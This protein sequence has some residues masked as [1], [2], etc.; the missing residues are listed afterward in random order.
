MRRKFTKYPQGYVKASYWGGRNE[1]P[2]NMDKI[3]SDD[4]RYYHWEGAQLVNEDAEGEWF[5]VEGESDN[6][7]FNF[8]LVC[9]CPDG[10]VESLKSRRIDK[11]SYTTEKA[12]EAMGALESDYWDFYA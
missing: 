3:H 11:N 8:Y 7:N 1:L 4:K 10:E 5:I 9:V 12:Y 6:Q 2:K